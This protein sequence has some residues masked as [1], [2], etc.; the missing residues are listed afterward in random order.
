MK[1]AKAMNDSLEKIPQGRRLPYWDK[2]R[3]RVQS[4]GRINKMIEH[5]SRLTEDTAYRLGKEFT[6]L[7][8]S[9]PHGEFQIAVARTPL[10]IRT[11]QNLM[12]HARECD[13]VNRVLPYHPNPKAGTKNATVA[14]LES[15]PDPAEAAEIKK[16]KPRFD[17]EP[18]A[19]HASEVAQ[20]LLEI[21]EKLTRNRKLEEMEDV[22]TQF[23]EKAREYI[24]GRRED[25]LMMQGSPMESEL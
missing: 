5:W 23:E 21:F 6:W 24:E 12:R 22:L 10:K 7:K 18:M 8:N 14:L 3:N 9:L 2:P 4:I 1:G 13:E 19:W 20:T 25:R 11:V 17:K 15:P 16:G